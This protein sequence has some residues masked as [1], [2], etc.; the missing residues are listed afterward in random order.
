[1]EALGYVYNRAAANLRR[2][3]P[4]LI[5]LVINDLRNGFFTEIAT[6]A[7][8]TFARAGYATVVANT[9]E[10]PRLQA[11]VTLSMIEHG[12]SAVMMSPAYGDL[13]SVQSLRAARI[14]TLQVLRRERTDD[15]FPF[16]SFDY[17][18]GSR[19]AVAHLMERGARRIVFVGGVPGRPITGERMTGFC[20][21]LAYG[22]IEGEH[23]PGHPSR[24]FGRDAAAGV[25][26][27]RADAVVWFSGLVALGLSAGLAAAGARV[28][29]DILLVGFDDVEECALVH[30]ALSSVR[31]D[32]D[33]FGSACA[34]AM[35]E[36][37]RDGT[38]P[39]V[40]RRAPVTLSARAST[41]VR[42]TA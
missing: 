6:A 34:G 9:S 25:L 42:R 29:E 26:A 11:Q 12:V 14:P 28:G 37:L 22:A 2:A 7:Q 30:P 38:E 41:G 15:P 31:C 40:E 19:L 35:V 33:A 20:E 3:G 16:V 27:L 4:G 36:W 21:R 23:L 13:Q 8:M 17:A 32:S 18:R 24:R 1:M 10:D 5:G 39:P